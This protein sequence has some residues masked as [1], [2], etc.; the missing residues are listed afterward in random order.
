MDNSKKSIENKFRLI[1]D[2]S[3]DISFSSTYKK[4]SSTDFSKRFLYEAAPLTE[5][6]IYNIDDFYEI[7]NLQYELATYIYTN[8]GIIDVSAY[9]ESLK[10]VISAGQFTSDENFLLN[11][12]NCSNCSFIEF[13]GDFKSWGN[14]FY[15]RP[16]KVYK[17]GKSYE[18]IIYVRTDKNNVSSFGNAI[19]IML[20]KRLLAETLPTATT[21]DGSFS[22]CID[23]NNS[24]LFGSIPSQI[25]QPLYTSL[26]NEKVPFVRTKTGSYYVFTRQINTLPW[27]LVMYRS[28][29]SVNYLGKFNLILKG[30]IIISLA[31]G[32]MLSIIIALKLYKPVNSILTRILSMELEKPVIRAPFDFIKKYLYGMDE[33]IHTLEHTI[34][35]YREKLYDYFILKLFTDSSTSAD[36]TTYANTYKGSYHIVIHTVINKSLNSSINSAYENNSEQV[37][38]QFLE[39]ISCSSTNISQ[40]LNTFMFAEKESCF[41]IL[42]SWNDSSS[43]NDIRSDNNIISHIRNAAAAIEKCHNCTLKI[44]VGSVVNSLDEIKYSYREA[45]KALNYCILTSFSEDRFVEYGK[46]KYS[47]KSQENEVELPFFL[48]ADLK[49][50]IISAIKS[51]DLERFE[52][53]STIILAE[54]LNNRPVS[55]GSL[56]YLCSE[57]FAAFLDGTGSFNDESL[58]LLHPEFFT[59]ISDVLGLIREGF[60]TSEDSVTNAKK[61]MLKQK[62]Y[63]YLNNNFLNPEISLKSVA[64]NVGISPYLVS[65]LISEDLNMNF[66]NYINF[67]RVNYAEKLLANKNYSIKD[68]VK[69]AGFNSAQVFIRVF[70]KYR[71]VTPGDY[72]K[73]VCK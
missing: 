68:V 46:F 28:E 60:K 51:K 71:G 61:I 31:I 3:L 62:M 24:V 30:I 22:F 44:G 40:R 32:L 58:D 65:K 57:L 38:Q 19:V 9:F 70:K 52:E 54:N 66:E 18:A 12:Y 2:L 73:K 29:N 49:M 21:T 56:S 14:L 20:E 11:R 39:Y 1:N 6:G 72:R 8:K 47:L 7:K 10:S 16:L 63:Q 37:K 27:K 36:W 35:S 42:V 64:N 53:L 48:P 17:N 59:N 15:S 13:V 33:K 43:D 34:D 69:Y 45:K 26:D 41:N 23:E 5:N 4:I 50:D 67:H 55:P 25:S